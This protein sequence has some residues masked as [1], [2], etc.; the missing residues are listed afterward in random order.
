[1]NV[2]LSQ[3]L[4]KAASRARCDMRHWLAVATLGLALAGCGEQDQEAANNTEPD[5]QPVEESQVAESAPD[6]AFSRDGLLSYEAVYELSLSRADSSTGI[7]GYD[8]IMAISWFDAC[9][10]YTSDQRLTAL[11]WNEEGGQLVA[12][13]NMTSWEAADQTLFRFNSTTKYNGQL[14]EEAIGKANRSEPGKAGTLLYSAPEEKT[15]DMDGE[16]LFPSE[17]M[18][19]VLKAAQSGKTVF[20]N[21]MTDGS[22]D[23]VIYETVTFIGKKGT[24]SKEEFKFDGGDLLS[25]LDYW[26]VQLG[27]HDRDKPDSL[28]EVEI[29]MTLF[30]NGVGTDL[31]LN[32]GDFVLNGQL[33]N[34]KKLPNSGC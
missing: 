2:G 11:I 1:M 13:F 10:G 16:V 5:S 3:V 26:P 33:T 8:G 6:E 22:V 4:F 14:T 21:P 32:Y 29:G 24:L 30:E 31:V 34:L 9:E 17:Y 19:Q 12:D 27:Y 7:I 28:P 20:E 15:Y 23:T 18:N 25:G